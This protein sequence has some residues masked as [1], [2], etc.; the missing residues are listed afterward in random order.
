MKMIFDSPTSRDAYTH[1]IRNSYLKEYRRY[2]PDTKR[3]ALTVGYF[4]D[5][6]TVRKRSQESVKTQQIPRN[7]T[8]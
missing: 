5:T 1:Q 7:I 4:F 3:D 6:Y 2:A 8:E